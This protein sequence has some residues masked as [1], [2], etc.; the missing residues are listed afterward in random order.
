MSPVLRHKICF[1]R[2]SCHYPNSNLLFFHR[3]KWR[4]HAEMSLGKICSF[5]FKRC[6]TSDARCLNNFLFNHYLLLLIYTC[7]FSL[8]E[9]WLKNDVI[10]PNISLSK[11]DLFCHQICIAERLNR[12][13]S[14]L[15]TWMYHFS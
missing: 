13:F 2:L 5:R 14:Q 10:T 9:Q 11:F 15:Q 6:I 12:F 4:N 3:R 7:C 8:S 1:P